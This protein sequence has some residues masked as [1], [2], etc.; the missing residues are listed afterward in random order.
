MYLET[1][2]RIDG[3]LTEDDFLGALG[4]DPEVSPDL[5][6]TGRHPSPHS[7][8]GAAEFRT[9]RPIGFSGH[10]QKDSIAPAV[11]VHLA[12]LNERLDERGGKITASREILEYAAQQAIV[13]D[14]Q[15]Q[16]ADPLRNR[17][18]F[19]K[20]VRGRFADGEMAGHE[21]LLE[22]SDRRGEVDLGQ[23]HH[24]VDRPAATLAPLPVHELWA[25]DRQ[26][27][28]FGVPFGPVVPVALGAAE[29]QHGLQRHRSD[30][31]GT[32]AEVL[33]VHSASLS[34]SSS[35]FP[36]KLRQFF[37]WITWLVA[38]SRSSKAP[39]RWLFLRNDP[40]SLKPRLEVIRVV[41][42]LCRFCI[43]VK[44]RPTC[45]GSTSTYPISS[46]TRH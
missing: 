16:P 28:L 32:P 44:N 33:E 29:D 34:P 45:A 5:A 40:H 31:G 39:V 13:G 36:R 9:D 26:R 27:A 30:H 23:V 3:G 6:G 8:P 43:S 37:M 18:F 42:V 15:L 20:S 2:D 17:G 1:T 35:S 21:V 11:R 25:R 7:R 14:G 10:Q 41:L 4:T 38:V 46:I 19:A 24:Q 22:P 12:G